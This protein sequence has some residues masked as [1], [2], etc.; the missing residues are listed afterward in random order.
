MTSKPLEC[1]ICGA[2]SCS[3]NPVTIVNDERICDECM[4]ETAII[5]E[6]QRAKSK[7]Y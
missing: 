6:E 2:V 5:E 3:D 4:R 1:W 7:R